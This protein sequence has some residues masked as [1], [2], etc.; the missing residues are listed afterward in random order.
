MEESSVLDMNHTELEACFIQSLTADLLTGG[1]IDTIGRNCSRQDDES[2]MIFV[3][4]EGVRE[5]EMQDN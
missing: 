2:H 1:Y 4:R 5:K 3:K